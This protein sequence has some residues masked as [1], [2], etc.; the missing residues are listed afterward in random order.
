MMDNFGVRPDDFFA[1]SLKKY[2]LVISA[3]SKKNEEIHFIDEI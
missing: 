1:Q 3:R 2:L